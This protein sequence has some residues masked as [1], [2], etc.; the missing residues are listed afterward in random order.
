MS[1]EALPIP[2]D[3]PV[4]KPALD[5]NRAEPSVTSLT[6]VSLTIRYSTS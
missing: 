4:M 1:P 6:R 5:P 2:D 3:W